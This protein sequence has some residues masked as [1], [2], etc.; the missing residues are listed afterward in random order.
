MAQTFGET[1]K[2]FSFS[3]SP[4]HFMEKHPFP[5]AGD[6]LPSTSL[7]RFPARNGNTTGDR[8]GKD[9]LDGQILA[10]SAR[11]GVNLPV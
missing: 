6:F 2:N 9:C 4:G 7:G 5:T 3:I 1:M 10:F 11:T 8:H